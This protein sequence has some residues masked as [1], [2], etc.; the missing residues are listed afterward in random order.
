MDDPARARRWMTRWMLPIAV[1]WLLIW[2]LY[3]GYRLAFGD[4]FKP[5]EAVL[6]L[7]TG[8]GLVL[9]VLVGWLTHRAERRG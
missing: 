9:V 1:G 6:M 2:V 5:G 4:S 8:T 7:S 3:V